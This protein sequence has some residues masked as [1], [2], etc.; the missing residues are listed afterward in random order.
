M[1]HNVDCYLRQQLLG[2]VEENFAWVKHRPHQGCSG[3]ITLD[4]LT[5]IYETYAVIA[6]AEWFGNDKR[7]REAYTPTDPIKVLWCHINN[8]VAYVDAN[9]TPY[10]PKQVVDNTYQLVFNTGIFTA[11]CREWNKWAAA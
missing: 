6:N 9:S 7:F 3:S 8:T 2:A 1:F 10:S 4:L 11:G 5:H